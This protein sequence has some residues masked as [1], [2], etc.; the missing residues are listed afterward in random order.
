MNEPG[1]TSPAPLPLPQAKLK[2][3]Q[4]GN[5]YVTGMGPPNIYGLGPGGRTT[6]PNDILLYDT[7]NGILV[8]QNTILNPSGNG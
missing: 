2:V 3:D 6:N 8:D 5:I 7:F 4:Q 1:F